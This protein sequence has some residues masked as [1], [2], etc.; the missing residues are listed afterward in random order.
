MADA[1]ALARLAL[2]AGKRIGTFLAMLA[3]IGAL[4]GGAT[5]AARA[6]GF[7]GDS[8]KLLRVLMLGFYVVA[9]GFVMLRR[10]K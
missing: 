6:L 2:Q 9:G 7:H 8:A 3:G 10:G 1:R 5:L 4:V